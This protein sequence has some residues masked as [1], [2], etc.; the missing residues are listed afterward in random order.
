MFFDT[1]RSFF[2]FLAVRTI[3]TNFVTLLHGNFVIVAVRYQ[4]YVV[5][6]AVCTT[7]MPHAHTQ[8]YWDG[9]VYIK[10]NYNFHQKE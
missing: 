4:E 3:L 7:H 8:N 6:I 5:T 1:S 9:Y 10:L 2:R